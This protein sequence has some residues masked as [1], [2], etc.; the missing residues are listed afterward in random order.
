MNA[1]D[2]AGR[3]A[4]RVVCIVQAR[5]GSTRLPGKVLRPILGKPMLGLLVERLTYAKTLDDIVVAT[6]AHDRD[7]PIE[8]LTRDR[9]VGCFRGSEDD[10]LDRVLR[11]AHAAR[12]DVIVEIT[13]DCPLM[14]PAL[15]D[16]VTGVYLAGAWDFVGN[17]RGAAIK[18]VY[19]DGFGIRVFA[20]AILEDVDRRARD[21]RDREHV[22]IYVWEHPERYSLFQVMGDVPAR[23]WDLRLTVDTAEDFALMQAIFE[24]LYPGNPAFSLGDVL[25]L[26]DAEPGLLD[27]N[28]HVR[29]RPD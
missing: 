16:E 24:R 15:V 5:M 19:P 10:V 2:G 29:R 7:D 11:A 14:D 22:S 13:G 8:A 9:G 21:R 26:V 28:R 27:L 1:V 23:Y 20:T 12:A 25:A 4:Q 3:G 6:T 17:R 18:P